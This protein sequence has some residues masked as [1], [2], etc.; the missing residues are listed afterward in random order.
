MKKFFPNLLIVCGSGRNIGKTAVITTIIAN[1]KGKNKIVA[2]KVSPHFHNDKQPK[3]IIWQDIDCNIYLENENTSKDS[4]LFL[5]SGADPVY[6]IETKDN[7][8]K[9][10]FIFILKQIGENRLIICESGV[11]ARIFK[12]GL[13]I[14]VESSKTNFQDNKIL[15]RDI[16]DF[17]ITVEDGKLSDELLK[18]KNKITIFEN[19]WKLV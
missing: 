8:L 13:L 2:I 19:K 17:I 6:Y 3:T 4:S 12:P 5:Q 1:N 7:K 15:N 14:Y 11:L 18:V 10:A 16:A 9:D